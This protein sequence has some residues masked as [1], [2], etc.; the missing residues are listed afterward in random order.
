MTLNLGNA[1]LI[2]ALMLVSIGCLVELSNFEA[3]IE[4]E[5]EEDVEH[6][7]SMLFLQVTQILMSWIV[8][9]ATKHCKWH[10]Q[11]R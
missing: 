5:R 6:S 8:A 2:P 4:R 11:Q 9:M 10:L 7:T 1:T 3:N